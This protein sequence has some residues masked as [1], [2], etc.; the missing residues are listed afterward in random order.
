[1]GLA[2]LHQLRGRVGRGAAESTCVLLY[3]APLTEIAR[4]RLAVLRAT[5]DGFEISRRDLELRG[6]GELLGTRQTGLMQMRVADLVRDADLLPKVQQAAELMLADNEA[7]I[8]PLLRRW[9]RQGEQFGK[10]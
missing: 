9:V 5:N 10:V 8:A 1:M 6:P 4:E 7:N 3:K 2:Q